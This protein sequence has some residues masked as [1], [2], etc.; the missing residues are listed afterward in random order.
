MDARS[1]HIRLSDEA[2][3]GIGFAAFF[4]FGAVLT[5]AL[6]CTGYFG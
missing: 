1:N 6:A 2:K 3:F 5:S 4:I